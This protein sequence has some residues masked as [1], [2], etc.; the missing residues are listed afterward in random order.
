MIRNII[1]KKCKKEKIAGVGGLSGGS[2]SFGD[3]SNKNCFKIG[4]RQRGTNW[5][6]V[7]GRSRTY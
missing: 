3:V 4:T 2:S 6:N 1:Q 7:V 5:N